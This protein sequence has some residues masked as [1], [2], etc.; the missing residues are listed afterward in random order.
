MK[1]DFQVLT[2]VVAHPTL[3]GELAAFR[4][5]ELLQALRA[6]APGTTIHDIRFRVGPVDEPE[7]HAADPSPPPAPEPSPGAGA[8]RPSGPAAR[9]RSRSRTR[10]RDDDR[11]AGKG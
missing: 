10:G 5:A 6:G 3:L 4:K 1:M 9:G 8:R 11:A 2:V 7:T